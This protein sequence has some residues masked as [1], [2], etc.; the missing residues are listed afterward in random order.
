MIS[1]F[2]EIDFNKTILSSGARRQLT[3][4][5]RTIWRPDGAGR[6]GLRNLI[7]RN[8]FDL[9]RGTY[10]PLARDFYLKGKLPDVSRT[11]VR[12]R[13]SPDLVPFPAP[14]FTNALLIPAD[15]G[16]AGFHPDETPRPLER[17]TNIGLLIVT[18]EFD[19]GRPEQF[20]ENLTWIRSRNGDGDFFGSPFAELDRE[21]RRVK[22]YRG[23]SIVFSGN[24][25]LHFHFIFSTEHLLTVPCGA[26]AKDRFRDFRQA[27]ALL[28]NAHK[29]Y[30]DHVHQGFL[31]I[32]NPSM[33]AD[34]KL[35]SLTQWRRAPWGIRLLDED[36]VLG[37][38][39][40]TMVPQL[41]IREKIL[42]RAP[43]GNDGFLLP[44]SFSSADPVRMNRPRSHDTNNIAEFDESSMVELLGEVCSA[45]WGEWPKP[46]GVG[47][48][49]G[50]WL[51]RFRNHENDRNPS[52]IALGDH[53][54][55]Q[56]NGAHGFE[57]RQFF[58][59]DQ[60]TAQ[61]L[62]NHLAERLGWQPLDEDPAPRIPDPGTNRRNQAPGFQDFSRPCRVVLQGAA[63]A[64]R[65]LAKRAYRDVLGREM[66][67]RS[68]LGMVALVWSVEGIGKT[69]AR[70]P[71]LA[72]EALE[73]A[74]AHKTE[75]SGS[76]DS[77]SGLET[78]PTRRLKSSAGPIGFVSLRR[79]GST[80][81]MPVRA[82][83]KLQFLGMNLTT[84]IRPAFFSAFIT[85]SRTSLIAL[86][87]PGRIYGPIRPGLT[88]AVPCSV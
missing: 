30:W 64:D 88:G 2:P 83:A 41:M 44:E 32:L 4:I 14:L 72:N 67:Q 62:G 21:F 68:D 47:I 15:Y 9:N 28:H 16:G 26:V 63:S 20:E 33:P 11:L 8:V 17:A 58:L 12:V 40:G 51:F 69:T 24:K 10:V 25:S 65:D 73:D 53:R 19:S 46:V 5:V 85:L 54:R 66:A 75:S 86:N 52:T 82:R 49:D 61:E 39:R 48:Q 70:L 56:L 74:L 76:L 36:S 3:E 79:F 50:E 43:K 84:P 22:E 31:R 37:F 81:P 35:R 45:E 80:T 60:M 78:R 18:I 7:L 23:F 1:S 27:P 71:I 34:P 42:Q 6:A 55:L 77:H 13:P 87:E 38:P 59:P 57:Q 29:R